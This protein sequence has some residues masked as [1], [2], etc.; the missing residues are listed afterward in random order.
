MKMQGTT[1][2]TGG[3]LL[4]ALVCSGA[5]ETTK[6]SDRSGRV[7]VKEPA[8]QTFDFSF[9]GGTMTQFV[10]A[11]NKA[12]EAHWKD[13]ARPNLIVPASSSSIELPPMEL[14]AIDL[15]SL[16]EA[17]GRLLQ[18]GPVWVPVGKSTWVL[19]IL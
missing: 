3:W 5:E 19:Q 13:G 1:I 14:R 18:R 9:P 8:P 2:L 11:V 16:L 4:L 12:S 7:V 15:K 6:Q 10:A 17:V